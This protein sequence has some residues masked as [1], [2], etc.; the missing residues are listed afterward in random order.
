MDKPAERLAREKQFRVRVLIGAIFTRYTCIN[1][2][3]YL[4]RLIFKIWNKTAPL[5]EHY[6]F[7]NIRVIMFYCKN[8]QIFQIFIAFN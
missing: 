5:R 8:C 4:Y 6:F 1:T 2:N 3:R 7:S